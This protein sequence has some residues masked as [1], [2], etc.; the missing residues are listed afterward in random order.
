V[1]VVRLLADFPPPTPQ[2]T[3]CRLW[4]GSCDGDGYGVLTANNRPNSRQ[5][6][7]RWIWE[8][9]NG[10]IIPGIV[11]R[12]KCDNPPCYRLS[13]LELGT[14][15]DNNNDARQRDHL[16]PTLTLRP[17][18]IRT[19]IEAREAGMTYRQIWEAHFTDVISLS[20]VKRI[21]AIGREGFDAD[22]NRIIPPEPITKYQSW[23]NDD[24]VR[25]EPYL[26]YQ[27]EDEPG[28]TAGPGVDLPAGAA[29][30]P[31]GD[32]D[33]SGR[34]SDHGVPPLGDQDLEP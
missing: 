24:S 34:G 23:R 16:G 10:P 7:H 22:W 8:M 15:A 29:L 27:L 2:P 25:S 4:Q 18:Q 6:A 20:G 12:H 26:G 17:S 30:R 14:V 3:P 9:A 19:L 13:H 33:H 31:P 28:G 21:G 5:R 1:H 32:G 11:V